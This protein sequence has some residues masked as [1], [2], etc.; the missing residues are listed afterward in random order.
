MLYRLAICR[1]FLDVGSFLLTRPSQSSFGFL[2]NSYAD[3]KWF[4]CVCVRHQPGMEAKSPEQGAKHI[5]LRPSWSMTC[6]H[7]AYYVAVQTLLPL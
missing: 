6:R 7:L 3:I 4:W 1:D 2:L 5:V